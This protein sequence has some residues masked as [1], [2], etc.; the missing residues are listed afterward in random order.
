MNKVDAIKFRMYNTG[1]VGDCLLLLFMKGGAVSFSM[2]IDC[3]GW[4]TTP[5]AISACVEDINTTCGNN[6]DLLVVTHQ[7]LDHISGFNQAK[8][9]F[10]KI[11]VKEVWMSW[12]EDEDDEIAKI[13]KDRFGKK[14][15][16]LKGIAGKAQEKI[17]AHLAQKVNVRGV[18]KRMAQKQVSIENTL[19]LI[20]FEE[21]IMSVSGKAARPTN[22]AAMNYVKGKGKK[23]E[24]LKPGKVISDMSGAEGIKFFIL[25][26]PRDEDM[27]FFKIDLEEDEM[28]HLKAAKENEEEEEPVL[29]HIV[30]TGIVLQDGVSP[31]DDQ[32]YHAGPVKFSDEQEKKDY[33]WRG[34][35]TDWLESAAAIAMRAT[36]LTNNT[37]LAMAI[38]FEGS[39]RVILLPGDAQSGNWMGWHKPDVMKELKKNGGKNTEELLADTVFYKV[40]HH[41]SHNGTASHSG[42]D[43]V[44][45]KDLVA[46]MPLVQDKV[47]KEW[48]GAANFPAKKLYSVLIE[49]SKGRLVRTDVG[50]I[51]DAKAVQERKKLKAT[52][53][54]AFMKALK[55]GANYFEF[56]IK[57]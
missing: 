23:L 6:L 36:R 32:Y 17:K 8:T 53:R 39:G 48:G 14:L 2:L 56:T 5:A 50:L 19:S 10:D 18:G 57:G 38:E 27:H 41:G 1:S 25:G 7:H 20:A 35:E 34:I 13:L 9:E 28:Y 45:N 51:D 42:L 24:F 3:G 46:F 55:K 44:K 11:H 21:G 49:K 22:D 33:A 15:K 37:S 30:D 52:D 31:F 43:F 12:I 40:G 4:L 47:P 26:P 16:Q 54:N 29:E